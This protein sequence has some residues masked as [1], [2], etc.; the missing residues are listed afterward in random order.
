MILSLV[1]YLGFA[2]KPVIIEFVDLQCVPMVELIKQSKQGDKHTEMR[3]P[4]SFE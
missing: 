3:K 4:K 1:M 2:D